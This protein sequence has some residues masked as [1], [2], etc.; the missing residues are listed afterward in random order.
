MISV[1]VRSERRK[2]YLEAF[3]KGNTGEETK[4]GET[5]GKM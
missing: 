3:E 4:R 5:N 1:I 2:E